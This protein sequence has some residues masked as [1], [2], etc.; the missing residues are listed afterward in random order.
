MRGGPRLGSIVPFG[1][2]DSRI[3]SETH[4]REEK[5]EQVCKR[6]KKKNRAETMKKTVGMCGLGGDSWRRQ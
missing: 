3:N 2:G 6:E 4:V 1:D 5:R